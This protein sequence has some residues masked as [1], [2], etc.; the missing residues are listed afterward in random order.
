MIRDKRERAKKEVKLPHEG[1]LGLYGYHYDKNT[2]K[3][4]INEI[5]IYWVRQI[6]D[7]LID[8]WLSTNAMT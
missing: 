3:R 1:F 4:N 6:Y 2:N 7:W 5:E 8:K